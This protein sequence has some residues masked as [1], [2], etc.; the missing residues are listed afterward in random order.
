[1][2]CITGVSSSVLRL[3]VCKRI[4]RTHYLIADFS[5]ECFTPKWQSY[6]Y[7]TMALVLL[8]PIGI[9]LF[10]FMLLAVN[11]HRLREDRVKAQL[12][13]LYEGYRWEVWWWE[14]VDCFHKLFLTSVIAF[15][16]RESQLPVGMCAAT[17]YLVLLLRVNP[18]QRHSDDRLHLLAQNEIAL[19]LMAGNIFYFQPLDGAY[20]HTGLVPDYPAMSHLLHA[21]LVCAAFDETSDIAFS[22]VLILIACAFL[23][24]FVWSA[25]LVCALSNDGCCLQLG[26]KFMVVTIRLC[27]AT[28]RSGGTPGRKDSAKRSQSMRR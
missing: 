5:V 16:P 8:Y 6:A 4:E 11:R 12:G 20:G 10:F 18:Y 19:L 14:I 7:G 21:L 24:G 22:A 15:F 28:S 13:F 25:V 9:P 23:L 1:M 27:G 3:Y 17:L 26:S 2:I